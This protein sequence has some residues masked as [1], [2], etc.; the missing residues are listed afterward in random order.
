M[1][2]AD[3]LLQ[4]VTQLALMHCTMF[5]NLEESKALLEQGSIAASA[6]EV[7]NEKARIETEA[8][9]VDVATFR[10]GPLW[11]AT[12][13]ST[14]DLTVQ[15]SPAATAF[16]TLVKAHGVDVAIISDGVFVADGV[17]VQ[18]SSGAAASHTLGKEAL[19]VDVDTLTD[20]ALVTA[21]VDST[22]V[23][24]DF[25]VPA[26][27][28]AV[29]SNMPKRS[30]WVGVTDDSDLDLGVELPTRARD[31]GAGGETKLPQA[32][33]VGTHTVG[34]RR[35]RKEGGRRLREPSKKK[36]GAEWPDLTASSRAEMSF[37]DY[38]LHV[39][40]RSSTCGLEGPPLAAMSS[41]DPS[42]FTDDELM[43]A[44][45]RVRYRSVRPLP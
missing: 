22:V 40:A 2:E 45:F 36:S 1:A 35:R 30:L 9:S 17:K 16:G 3:N 5:D 29:A 18:D 11:A 26:S 12:V 43:D 41:D 34:T 37:A 42:D 21:M 24:D 23:Q 10:G 25:M 4:A 20:G 28:E 44:Q 6:G 19:G 39:V 15:D 38:V 8:H 7:G 14:E 27:L 13:D 33:L 32:V 31:E